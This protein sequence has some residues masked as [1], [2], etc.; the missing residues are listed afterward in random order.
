MSKEYIFCLLCGNYQTS[1]GG[2]HPG[3]FHPGPGKS[4]GVES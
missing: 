4:A 1:K 3:E 2:L